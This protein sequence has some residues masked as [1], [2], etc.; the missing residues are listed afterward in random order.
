M[1]KQIRK[2]FLLRLRESR[3]RSYIRFFLDEVHIAVVRETVWLTQAEMAELFGVK[4][5]DV[6]YHLKNLFARRI[7]Q[8]GNV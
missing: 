3:G 5:E 4:R 1:G 6:P 2:T 7:E 8:R